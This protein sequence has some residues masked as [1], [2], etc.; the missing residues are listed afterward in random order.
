VAAA[1]CT[2]ADFDEFRSALAEAG[3]SASKLLEAAEEKLERRK[4]KNGGGS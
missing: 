3:V 2:D 4:A 1:P